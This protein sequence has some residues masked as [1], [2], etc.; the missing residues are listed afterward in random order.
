MNH[1]LIHKYVQTT[2]PI[3]WESMTPKLQ[4]EVQRIQDSEL[5][6]DS[7]L[8]NTEVCLL[9]KIIPMFTNETTT[10]EELE[11]LLIKREN[12]EEN[13]DEKLD[14]VD[15]YTRLHKEYHSN[16]NLTAEVKNKYNRMVSWK[17]GTLHGDPITKKQGKR[18][19]QYFFVERI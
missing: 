7:S 5:Q 17:A 3:S 9:L 13:G 6:Q 8:L 12:N 4:F 11:T 1:F 15:E 18:L 2:Q 10:F 16:F 19:N 14:Y